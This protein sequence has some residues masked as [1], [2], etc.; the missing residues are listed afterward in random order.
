MSYDPRLQPYG[1][2]RADEFPLN[3]PRMVSHGYLTIPA[4]L[5][6]VMSIATIQGGYVL[7]I[8]DEATGR[9]EPLLCVGAESIEAGVRAVLTYLVAQGLEK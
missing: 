1:L 9:T 6:V 3:P 5:T 8:N 4:K 7:S 2:Q